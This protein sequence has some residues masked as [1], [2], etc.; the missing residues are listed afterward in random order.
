M[1]EL[2]QQVAELTMQ[3]EYQLRL[4]DLHVQVRWVQWRRLLLRIAACRNMGCPMCASYACL[5]DVWWSRLANK[6]LCM[7]YHEQ[8]RI[9][10][11]TDKLNAELEADRQ[12]FE[13]LLQDKNEQELEYEEKLKQVGLG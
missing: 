6:C 4:K 2:E 12:K 11:V 1:A 3:T 10:E 7:I 8:E 13:V 9:K 5:P